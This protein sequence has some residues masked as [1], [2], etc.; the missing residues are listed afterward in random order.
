MPA[1][2]WRRAPG[3]PDPPPPCK[4][5]RRP[6][7]LPSEAIGVR[8]TDSD[9]VLRLRPY[10]QRQPDVRLACLFGSQARGSAGPLSDIDVAV[11]LDPPAYAGCTRGEEICADLMQVLHRNDIDVVLADRAPALLRH[12]IARDGVL[13]LARG[14]HT[15]TRFVVDAVRDYVDTA[16]LRRL[17]EAALARFAGTSASAH[18]T[19]PGWGNGDA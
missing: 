3:R 14:R 4:S 10:F 7:M 18:R 5:S 15:V 16:P 9:L 8:D 11:L 6:S 12:R 17:R 1:H 19:A 2:R 13:I